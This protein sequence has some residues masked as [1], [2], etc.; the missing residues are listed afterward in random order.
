M[1]YFNRPCEEDPE[2]LCVTCSEVPEQPFVPGHVEY[3]VQL[4]WN[5]G[6]NSIAEVDGSL[7]TVFQVPAGVAGVVAGLR[8]LWRGRDMAFDPGRVEYGLY[9]T[10]AGGVN[11]VSVIERGNERISPVI[12]AADATF[13]I[14]RVGSFVTYRM[15]GALMYESAIASFGQMIVTGC[16]YAT[17]DSIL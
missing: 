3:G 16:L 1:T 6:A 17:G 8:S 10:S 14:R 2:T 4:G 12:R 11:L 5:A 7:H 15:N 13:E 9:F